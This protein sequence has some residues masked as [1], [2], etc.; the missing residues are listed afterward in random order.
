MKV[1]LTSLAVVIL[2][3][4]AGFRIMSPGRL[5][6][7]KYE[8]VAVIQVHP[9]VLALPSPAGSS[10]AGTLMTR[11]YMESEFETILSPQ[12]LTAAIKA[13]ELDTRWNLS[14]EETLKALKTMLSSHP[15]RGTDFIEIKTRSHNEDDAHDIADAVADSYIARRAASQQQRAQAALEAL[16]T[17]LQNQE[18]KVKALFVL[19]QQYGIPYFDEQNRNPVGRTE[20]KMHQDAQKRLVQLKQ[21]RDRLKIQLNKILEAKN[22]E[23]IPTAAGLEL[24]ENLVA[25]FYTRYLETLRKDAELEKQGLNETHPDRIALKKHAKNLMTDT[26]S[27]IISLKD[28]LATRIN[29]IERQVE[30]MEQALLSNE[31]KDEDGYDEYESRPRQL[32]NAGKEYQKAQDLLRQMK[33][34]QAEQRKLLK[35]P[36][37]VVTR[38]E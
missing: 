14:E 12:T 5:M 1:Y 13:I 22:D 7:F 28:V 34:Q 6:G 30:R 10:D 33:I 17:E 36:R 8:S 29:L 23:L 37:P 24:P 20:E 35:N 2:I 18:D 32:L 31:N 15:R 38:H 16:D 19:V 21:D 26:K 27:A 3:A 9:S 4:V 11:N 25:T